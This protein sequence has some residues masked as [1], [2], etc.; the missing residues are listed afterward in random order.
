MLQV[1]YFAFLILED[2]SDFGV[3]P[4]IGIDLA[5]TDRMLLELGWTLPICQCGKAD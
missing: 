2:K 4:G 5:C 1:E 3:F